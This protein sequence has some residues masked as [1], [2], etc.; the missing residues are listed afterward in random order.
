MSSYFIGPPTPDG[1][2]TV[3]PV[4]GSPYVTYDR[5]LYQTTSQVDGN[6]LQ[7]ATHTRQANTLP[8]PNNHRRAEKKR[9]KGPSDRY[10]TLVETYV[11]VQDHIARQI[12]ELNVKVG[13]IVFVNSKQQR[14]DQVD[15]MWVMVVDTSRTGYIPAFSACPANFQASDV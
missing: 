8:H 4:S 11:I 7:D 6:I 14:P 10:R 13:E 2:S 3:P 9:R 1:H 12:D 5:P 15:W